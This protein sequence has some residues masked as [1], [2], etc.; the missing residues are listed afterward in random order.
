MK[1]AT[2]TTAILNNN[3]NINLGRHLLILPTLTEL[4]EF[5]KKLKKIDSRNLLILKEFEILATD[6]PY[7]N[8]SMI[9]Q[10]SSITAH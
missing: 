2:T 9:L 10:S 1:A 4:S 8:Y 7:K 5:E 3:N 6:K